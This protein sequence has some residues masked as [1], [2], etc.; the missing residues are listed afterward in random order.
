MSINGTTCLLTLSLILNVIM[1]GLQILM[2]F[3]LLWTNSPPPE[4]SNSTSCCNGTFLNETNNNITNISQITNNFLKE[5]KFYWRAKSQMCEVKGW[6]PT[7]RG[8]PWGPEL[9]GDLILS[10]RAYVSCDLTSC[11]KFFIAYGLSAN[12]H[13][14]NTSME[15]EESLYKTPIGS[16]S[17]LSTSEM[18]LPGRSSSACFDGLK[19][20]VLV[21][22][23]RDR[24]SF[25]M[26]KYGEEVT[27]TFSASRGGPLRLPNSECICIEGSCFV[28]VSDG[29]NVNQS[30]H[31]IYE[32]QNGTVQRWK[33]LNTTGINFEY[34]TCYTINNLIKCTGTNLWND[35]KRPLLRFTKELNYQ[36]VEPCNGA[37]TD[38]PRGGLTT[39]SCKMAQEKGEGGIQGFI[40]DEKPAWT[41]K[42]KAESSQNGFVLEQIPNGIESEG[43][44]SLSYELFS[45]KRTGRSGFFQPKG[46]LIS[47]CQRICFW[48][49]IEDQTVGLGMIQELSTFC[50]INS[51]VQNIN[52]DS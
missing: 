30:V 38:F 33:Q 40:L 4:I 12:Q 26:I 50:G 21:A 46:D 34:S 49:E 51:P 31:R 17:T 5:E 23:G 13:L 15:W 25:I 39:P 45:N 36:I 47:G 32:L 9:P 10:R 14:L 3:I 41:S 44:V 19:W 2:P 24:N 8:F 29:P 11:F 18:I 42:T 35:A 27:D 37:P 16:A 1:I 43:T 52:W 28:I 6:V 20:T 22:N 7:H 48:L